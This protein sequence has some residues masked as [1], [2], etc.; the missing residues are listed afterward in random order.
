LLK[1]TIEAGLKLKTVKPSRLARINV[2]TTVQEKD[3]L[4]AKEPAGRTAI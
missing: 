3:A 2:D 1:E 4:V